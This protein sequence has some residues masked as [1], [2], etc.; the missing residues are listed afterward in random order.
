MVLARSQPLCIDDAYK[1]GDFD[2]S[3]KYTSQKRSNE[4]LEFLQRKVLLPRV[5]SL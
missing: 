4:T 2:E 1:L 3:R 5:C